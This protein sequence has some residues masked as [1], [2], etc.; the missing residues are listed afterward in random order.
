RR[1]QHDLAPAHAAHQ[2]T[3]RRPRRLICLDASG[4][5]QCLHARLLPDDRA[6][7]DR[8]PGRLRPAARTAAAPGHSHRNSAMTSIP[9]KLES[10]AKTFPDGTRALHPVDIA[11]E[12]GEKVAILGPSGCGKTTTLRIIAGLETPD[13]GGR[14]WFGDEDVTALPVEK[15][16]VGMVFQSYA[17]F[18]NM[19]VAENVA[20]GLKIRGVARAERSRRVEKMLAM[21]RI[22]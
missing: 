12:P 1:V 20:Y 17:L 16:N 18:P 21:M 8:P 11:F 22:A 3:A 6:A 10:C 19:S 4:D 7:A 2:D 9:V 13:P 14:V 15:R 5:R